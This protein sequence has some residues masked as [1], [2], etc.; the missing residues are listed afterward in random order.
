MTQNQDQW[1]RR[2]TLAVVE[3]EKALDL[4][5]MHFRFSIQAADVQSPPNCEVR[6]YNLSEETAKKIRSEYTRV[7]IQAGYEQ[8]AFGKIFE[9]TIRQFRIG[10]ESPTETYLDILAADGDIGY[11]FAICNESWQAG[12]TAVNHVQAAARQMGLDYQVV[13]DL[14]GSSPARLA[15]GKV[16]FGMAR[17]LVGQ[18][19]ATLGSTWSIQNGRIQV[20][21][22]QGYLPGEALVVNQLTGMVGMPEQTDEGIRVKML[23][24]PRLRV[25]GLIRLNSKDINQL[26]LQNPNSVIPFN[27]WTGIQYASKVIESTDGTYRVYVIEHEGDTR[28]TE[29]YSNVV[30]LAYDPAS[31]KVEPR[32]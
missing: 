13:A 20:I 28:G 31:N 5:E 27:Q 6:V 16:G 2:A 8:S 22:F 9:G 30:C 7:I 10:R 32:D 21:P 24:N 29:W 11:N 18:A 12:S 17:D 26:I 3:G 19:A 23:L 25:G 4:S 15:R 14:S 1:L